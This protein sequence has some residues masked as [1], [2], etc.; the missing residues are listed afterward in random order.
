[1]VA[2]VNRIAYRLEP[3]N[4]S[5]NNLIITVPST[6]VD[7][8]YQEALQAQQYQVHT[9]GF[10]QGNVPLAYIE[11]NYK[12]SLL[13]HTR[14][15]LFKFF[16]VRALYQAIEEEKLLIAGQPRL[17]DISLDCHQDALYSFELSLLEPIEILKWKMLPFKAPLRKNYK[18]I[19]RQVEGFISEEKEFAKNHRDTVEIGDWISF[20][21]EFL[22]N[23]NKKLFKEDPETFWLRIGGEEAD[24][25]LQ[26]IFLHKK[27][28]DKFCSASP[29]LQE[30]F[31]CHLHT[32]FIFEIEIKSLVKNSYFCFEH[33]KTHF[34][35]KSDKDVHRKLIEIF[36]YRNDVSLRRSMAEEALKLLIAKH[37]IIAPNHLVLRQQ[38]TVLESLAQSPDYHVY[39]TQP[40]F[41]EHVKKLAEKQAKEMILVDH[42]AINESINTTPQDISSYLNLLKRQ[43]TKEFIY[44]MP[45]KT[46]IDG[47]EIPLNQAF[48]KRCS[49]QEKVVNLL[50]YHLTKK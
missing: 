8:A 4:Q 39:K 15:L 19:D 34:R 30:F 36:S 42:L 2:K 37:H 13:D 41:K 44:F 45:P 32:N 23:K 27:V 14:E 11:R 40:N 50:I 10:P 22:N 24:I 3:V 31:S 21:I 17:T 48:L 28:G 26:D 35:L 46:K 6:Y 9:H 29:H 20:D 1:M 38:Q 47:Q 12:T 5:I 33:F 18:D 7:T 16:V 43:R 25:P 49:Q